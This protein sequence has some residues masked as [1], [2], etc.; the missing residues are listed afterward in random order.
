MWER[1]WGHELNFA[2]EIA[3]NTQKDRLKVIERTPE[4]PDV[5]QALRSLIPEVKK[6]LSLGGLPS[7]VA[8]AATHT[9]VA[10]DLGIPP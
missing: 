5:G 8:C 10:L 9:I 1:G 2:K 7:G 3:S 4:R 6:D